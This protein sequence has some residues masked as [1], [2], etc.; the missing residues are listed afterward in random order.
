M[1]KILQKIKDFLK[2]FYK[3]I[4]LFLGICCYYPQFQEQGTRR[5]PLLDA[6]YAA[7]R[8]Y[9]G[10]TESG[11]EIGVLLQIARFMA[12]AATLSI[13]VNVFN[14]AAD[15]VNLLKFLSSESTVVY[16]DSEYAGYLYESL[17]RSRRIRGT[18]KFIGGAGRYLLM[19]S[20]EVKNITFFSTYYEQ[21]KKARVYLMLNDISRQSIA[22]PRI[23][24]FS[25]AENC[26]RQYWRDYPVLSDERIAIVGFG[27]VG[28]NI[29]LYGL[30]VNLI[31]PAQ[32]MEYHIYGDGSGFRREHTE[33]D[34]MEPDAIFFHDD[35]VYA[36]SELAAFDRIILC[37]DSRQQN[38]GTLSGLLA[39]APVRNPVYVYAPNGDIISGLFGEENVVCF[40][41]ARE[42]ASIDMILNQK[43]MEA[44]RRQHEY[45]VSRY[46]GT[47]WEQL[48]SFKRY[49]N[50]S[51]SDYMSVTE[52]LLREGVSEEK[53]AE[54]EHIRWCRYH[55]LNNWQYAPETD[56]ARRRHN[57]LV[58]FDQ[59]SE[60]EKRKDIEAIRA[61][62]KG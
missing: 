23:T 37:G 47:P 7:L 8:L 4:P 46:G 13:L 39:A 24:V 59:L 32:H 19:F 33:L 21:M 61:K 29:L 43:S 2:T 60:E 25:I 1:K 51:S 17:P 20:D 18:D 27:S 35:G 42:M 40:G 57:C 14:K 9:S 12:L 31:D 54:L 41:T 36:Y 45:Y 48:N 34:R 3:I 10:S 56:A 5:F 55:Y 62:S 50:V 49:S 11:V 58:P 28:Q 26:A 15:I 30:Q 53:L 38:I 44:A 22:N 52:R 6:V 16:G